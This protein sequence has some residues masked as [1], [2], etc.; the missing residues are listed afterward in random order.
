M[1][2]HNRNYNRKYNQTKH[3]TPLANLQV[4]P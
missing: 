4:K 1:Y 2:S 3:G